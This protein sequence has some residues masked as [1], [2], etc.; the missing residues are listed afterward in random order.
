ML[1]GSDVQENVT[2]GANLTQS[3]KAGSVAISYFRGEWIG[4]RLPT[5]LQELLGFW[6]AASVLAISS[7]AIAYGTDRESQF[8]DEYD[9]NQ[10]I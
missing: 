8:E 6:L 4:T 10:G 3:L 2:P 5:V 7:G 1:A 9:L